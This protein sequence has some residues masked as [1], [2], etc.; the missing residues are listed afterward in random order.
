[1]PAAKLS[2]VRQECFLPPLR[3]LP[4]VTAPT[5]G[6]QA[7][8]PER[9]H[10][11]WPFVTARRRRGS[12]ASQVTS[13]RKWLLK[14]GSTTRNADMCASV[15]KASRFGAVSGKDDVST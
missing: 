1:M 3:T 6:N 12:T 5:L 14:R 9:S 8:L 2:P 13:H 15:P 11:T 10:D 4:D 7:G